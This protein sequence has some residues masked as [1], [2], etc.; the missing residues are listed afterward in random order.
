MKLSAPPPPPP[1]PPEPSGP[2]PGEGDPGA[3]GNPPAQPVPDAAPAEKPAPKPAN[4]PGWFSG[5][6]A[7]IALLAVGLAFLAAS[8]AARNSDLWVH[9]AAGK[10]LFNGEYKLGTDPFSYAGEARRW[11]NHSWLFDAGAYLLYGNP[12]T[13]DPDTGGPAGGFVLVLVKALAVA[14]AA[15]L[16]IAIRRSGFSLFPWAVCAALAVLA[17]AP[18]L[19]LGPHL[20]S[21]VLLS[22]MLFILFRIPSRPNSWRVP[23]AIG[24][25]FCLWS[26]MD[27]WFILGPLALSLM[28]IGELIQKY[29]LGRTD[30]PDPAGEPL[31]HPTVPTLARAL[32]VGGL[33]CFLN[34][35][36]LGVWNVPFELLKSAAAAT[37]P[38]SF[39]AMLRSPMEGSFW[40]WSDLAGWLTG[41]SYA[42]LLVG[43]G[44][45]LGFGVGRL[46]L[47]HVALWIGF[48]LLSLR[49]TAA[50]PFF[51]V[52][53]VPL[54]AAQLNAISARM[55]LGT[56]ADIGTRFA[57]AGSGF[58]RVLAILG[59][60]ALCAASYPGWLH[61]VGL[62]PSTARRLA[63]AVEPDPA[64]VR[65]AGEVQSWR[66]SGGLPD[67]TRGFITNI[68][69]ADYCAWFAPKEKVFL[70]S[71]LAH[72]RAEIAE[73]VTVRSALRL[74]PQDD[75]PKQARTI[76]ER[77][78]SQH[79]VGYVTVTT[80]PADPL[81]IRQRV[82]GRVTEL[83]SVTEG[84]TYH[85]E[86]G[87]NNT[88]EMVPRMTAPPAD[89]WC[90]WYLDG[91]TTVFG[92]R[93]AAP[94]G[95]DD[96]PFKRL[97]VDPVE[98]AFGPGVRPL[99][100][101]QVSPIPQ[102]PG[103][104][105]DF[106]R[107]AQPA[108]W[109]ADESMRWGNYKDALRVRHD[110]EGV[111]W[112]QFYETLLP[113]VT[114]TGNGG[115][116]GTGLL[117]DVGNP[118]HAVMFQITTAR[119]PRLPRPPL[120]APDR[121]R[122]IAL[123]ELR[124]ARRAIAASPDRPEGYLA[125]F[126]AL[127]DPDLPLSESEKAIGRVTALRQC[128]SRFPPPDKFKAKVY[129]ASPTLVARQLAH[130]YL[131]RPMLN[132]QQAPTGHF[133]G[134]KVNLE[135]IRE[136][137][138]ESVHVYL[139]ADEAQRPITPDQIARR[140]MERGK[141]M[142]QGGLPYRGNV[143]GQVV[144]Q[145]DDQPYFLPLDLV[146]ESLK[147]A[148]DYAAVEL[149]EEPPK[150]REAY[151]EEL[152]GEREAVDRLVRSPNAA[153][154][155]LIQ[156]D[157]SVFARYTRAR[158]FGLTGRAIQ[159]LK[160]LKESD[161]GREFQNKL[162][163][164]EVGLQLVAME[165]TVGRLEDAAADI[166]ALKD[167][168]DR[169]AAGPN[170]DPRLQAYQLMLRQLEYHAAVLEGNYQKAG[171]LY[172]ELV[173]RDVEQ[174]ARTPVPPPD[175]M[176]LLR[177]APPLGSA[178]PP[179][180]GTLTQLRTWLQLHAAYLEKQTQLALQREDEARYFSRRGVLYLF[181]GDIASARRMFEQPGRPEPA[182]GLATPLQRPEA[183]AYIRMIDQAAKAASARAHP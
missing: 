60:L 169:L 137:I 133:Y 1:P 15:A 150:V 103:M 106:V 49:T 94:S 65:A 121:F 120:A 132:S 21:F 22:A 31:N 42:V 111:V 117:L 11:V 18:R 104:L 105:E 113:G 178:A 156:Q 12:P 17:S 126:Q 71:R 141:W 179:G 70:N 110:L 26:N 140:G 13:P 58:Q 116:P 160:D 79:H 37:D 100:A 167:A 109:Q 175:K 114:W 73:F 8:F 101:A 38:I 136:L 143:P 93:K 145:L 173:G 155:R 56:W 86:P 32:V 98:L 129:S 30:E 165:L 166:A 134:L 36:F 171:T 81:S 174:R 61:P 130:L 90:V 181:E 45:A 95:P 102:P 146:R 112:Q 27:E 108:P 142:P 74:F 20:A 138:G 39:R 152:K 88:T 163:V 119:L 87:P 75:P 84:V 52:V 53:A 128:L 82:T 151:A 5:A 7:I 92:W 96:S 77:I 4:W 158:Q 176:F 161:W 24:V 180:L 25:T 172:E 54:I 107:S 6:D 144:R 170:A 153:Y 162:P 80:G 118:M 122:A 34:P 89:R 139:P 28:L 127:L 131:G 40:E 23:I 148:A 16:L 182:W 33:A 177:F 164:Q 124:A 115:L 76:L 50:I 9:L 157:G 62:D 99:P 35:H 183:V 47:A 10:R 63:W 67:D 59:L 14:L 41:V 51:A 97:Q 85:P 91:R 83:F 2:S 135:M 125:L 159:T 57:L 64:L 69:L 48:A 68:P 29:S 72:H 78:L 149:A 154:E 168:F 46:R 55:R 147:L 19:V 43:G 66:E 44:V 123:L 3:A